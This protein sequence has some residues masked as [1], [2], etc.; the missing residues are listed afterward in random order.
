M[1]PIMPSVISS[2][3]NF[4]DKTRLDSRFYLTVGHFN[5]RLNYVVK[6]QHITAVDIFIP[7]EFI[8]YGCTA[9]YDSICD[10][11]I[12][13]GI[14]SL[15]KCHLFIISDGDDTC[16]QRYSQ[17]DANYVCTEAQRR[18]WKIT[19]CSTDTSLL[20]VKSIEFNM[21]DITCLFD[22]LAL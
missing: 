4:V 2:L 18:N 20:N 6:C 1:H 19:H 21:D 14:D 17:D 8:L 12:D 15:P 10:V 3:N 9:L 7:S 22:D 13:V 16:S 11:I 5:D